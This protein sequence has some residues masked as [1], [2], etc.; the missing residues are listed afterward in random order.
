MCICSNLT[1]ISPLEVHSINFRLTSWLGYFHFYHIVLNA[2]FVKVIFKLTSIFNIVAI[3]AEEYSHFTA[4]PGLKLNNKDVLNSYVIER[5][6]FH[7]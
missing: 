4:I 3:E 5:Y 7:Y 6:V 1:C 2:S